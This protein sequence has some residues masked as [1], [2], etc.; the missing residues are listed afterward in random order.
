MSVQI[1]VVDDLADMRMLLGLTLR[2]NGWNVIEANNGEQA[3][4]AAYAQQPDIIL[5]DYDMP[6]MNGLEVCEILRTE[7]ETAE[8]PIIIYTGYGASHMRS[9]ALQA[10]A[11]AFLLKPIT[12]SQLREEIEEILR[13]G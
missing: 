12:P 5:M 2:R 4:D 10:G 3:L 11:Q 1:L 13:S 8:I 7:P 6:G 9:Q